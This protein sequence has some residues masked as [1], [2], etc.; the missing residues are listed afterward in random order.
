MWRIV[1][2]GDTNLNVNAPAAVW[3]LQGAENL[4]DM[5]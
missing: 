3:L 1:T 2:Q 5:W 4:R